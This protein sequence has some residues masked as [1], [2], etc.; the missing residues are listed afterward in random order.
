MSQTD[1]KK[2][3]ARY[4]R[5]GAK[6]D[7]PS[8]LL[9]S[10]EELLPRR[11]RALD[12][13]GGAG[14]HAVWLARRGLDVTLT[15][16]SAEGI[17]L[18]RRRAAA[19]GV[20][21]STR[22]IDLTRRRLPPGPWDAI[23]SFYYLQRSL[24][25]QFATALA[26][27]GLLVFAQP[28]VTNLQR[29]PQ[30]GRR[31][32]LDDGELPAL[33]RGLEIIDYDEDWFESGRHEARVVAR[34]PLPAG[35]SSPG[36][37]PVTTKVTIYHNPRCTKS[38]QTLKL[39]QEHNLAPAV[40]EY[41]KTPPSAATLRGLLIKLGLKPGELIRRKEYHELGLT[42]TDDADELIQRMADHP[43]II[44]RPIVVAGPRARLGRP[45]ERV[46]EILPP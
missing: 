12:V 35:T 40:I 2:W 44:E 32:L 36:D 45:P 24:F 6:S 42:D 31:F 19:A 11:G 20:K 21:I 30:P 16:I 3:D 5:R 1:C 7:E 37:E 34:R 22:R 43:Q 15:D 17:R 23:V 8:P 27:G 26:P 33:V 25:D 28:T 13:A 41:L 14:R 46:L 4:R 9:L 18:A 39:L 29:H 38:R 10:L